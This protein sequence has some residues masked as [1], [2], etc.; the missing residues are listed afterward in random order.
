MYTCFL[1]GRDILENIS[2]IY[3]YK[4][5]FLIV[6]EYDGLIL[7]PTREKLE[8][9]IPK[10]IEDRDHQKENQS[11][12]S[13]KKDSPQKTKRVSSKSNVTKPPLRTSKLQFKT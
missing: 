1:S 7:S 12:C 3:W 8:P 11:R 4:F 10:R 2:Y 5:I 13:P 9:T 6:V